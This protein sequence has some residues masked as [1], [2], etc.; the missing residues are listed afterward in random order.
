MMSILI[1]EDD[2]VSYKLLQKLLAPYGEC[3]TVTSGPEAVEVHTKA[4]KKKE[5]FDLVC[6]DIMLP[7]MNGL[8]VLENIRNAEK[9]GKTAPTKVI[10]VTALSDEESIKKSF[11]QHAEAYLVKPI[12][13]DKLASVMKKLGFKHHYV[14]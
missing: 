5:P 3:V 11:K 12:Y 9:K 13:K 4:L 7:G 14:L 10:M 2:F 6:L 8:E 1:V